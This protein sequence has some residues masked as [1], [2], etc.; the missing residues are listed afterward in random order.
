M[1][2]LCLGLPFVSLRR[3]G[4]GRLRL[5]GGDHPLFCGLVGPAGSS[6][7][8]ACPSVLLSALTRT[9]PGLRLLLPP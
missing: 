5:P 9:G 1:S 3:W 8:Q 7:T 4:G 6:M 2:E